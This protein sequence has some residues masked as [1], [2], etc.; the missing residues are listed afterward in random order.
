MMGAWKCANCGLQQEE[1]PRSCPNCGLVQAG[2]WT[3]QKYQLL[4]S[5]CHPL[6]LIMRNQGFQH[7]FI[8]ACAGSGVVQDWKTNK[9]IDG[10]P[11]VMAKTREWVE[12][13]I[14]NKTKEPSVRCKFIEINPETYK[15]LKRSTTPYQD[16][17]ECIPGDMN[18]ELDKI[19]GVI[20]GAFTFVYI[21]PFGL[22]DPVIRYETV[23]R[24]LKRKFTELFIHF[25]WEGLSR[26]AGQLQN[27]DH[28][29]ETERKKARSTVETINSYMQGTEWQDVWKRTP[30]WL[31]RKA[32]V[33]LYISG[34]KAYYDFPEPIEMPVGSKKPIYYLIFTTRNETGRKIVKD[35]IGTMRRKGVEPLERWFAM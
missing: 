13:K 1:R 22:G 6:S 23:E 25:S 16:F 7:Y 17:A 31:R 18:R 10:S 24:V 3:F 15:I 11:M 8:D 5:Y 2:R 21:D 9:L 4:E 34:L 33:N 19:L 32:I 28:P 30:S 12:N 26:A 35:I 27:I 20:P 29:D 14:K